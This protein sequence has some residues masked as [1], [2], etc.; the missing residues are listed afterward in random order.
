[1]CGRFAR[2]QPLTDWLESLGIEADGDMLAKLHDEGPR[3]NIPPGTKGWIAAFDTNGELSLAEHKWNFPTSRGNR[4]NVRS[5]TAHRVPDYRESFDHHRCV[6]L[7]NGFYEPKGAKTEK[8]RPWY[9]FRPKDESPLFLGAIAKEEGFSIL[10]REP[11]DPVA[12]VHDRSPVM[13]PADRVLEFLDADI[14]GREAL[15]RFAPSDYGECLEGWHVGDSAKRPG[16]EGAELI[17]RVEPSE[18]L[19]D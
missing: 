6:V 7:A 15:R 17:D 14:P 4:I 8:Y 1:M 16:N 5:E 3:Y 19:F 18:D 2:Y 11:V 12:L 9:F 10:T 13:V